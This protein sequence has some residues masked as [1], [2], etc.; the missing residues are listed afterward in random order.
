M[1]RF[2]HFIDLTA[3]I[4]DRVSVYDTEAA[5]YSIHEVLQ[6]RE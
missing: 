4:V 5:L 2:F 6:K 1:A 3:N